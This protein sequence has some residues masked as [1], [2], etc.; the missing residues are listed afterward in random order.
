MH[1]LLLC[2]AVAW[3]LWTPGTWATCPLCT[4]GS[5]PGTQTLALI[6]STCHVKSVRLVPENDCTSHWTFD[7][8]MVRYLCSHDGYACVVQDEPE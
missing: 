1:L 3:S 2:L 4:H 5:L 6:L 8:I 7:L